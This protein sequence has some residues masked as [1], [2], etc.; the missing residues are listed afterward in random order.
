MAETINL[1]IIMPSLLVVQH[2]CSKMSN[3][4]LLTVENQLIINEKVKRVKINSFWFVLKISE[5]ILGINWFLVFD[6]YSSHIPFIPSHPPSF[7]PPPATTTSSFSRHSLVL[8]ILL[9]SFMVL[10]Q[11]SAVFGKISRFTAFDGF[12]YIHSL[13][14]WRQPSFNGLN[15]LTS[16]GCRMCVA[17]GVEQ[18]WWIPTDA[19]HKSY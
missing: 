12:P 16:A 5:F 15:T 6:F 2:Y 1:T 4:Y 11:L 7:L 13:T 18:R 9:F 8:S 14:T 17:F 3:M 19:T 10:K